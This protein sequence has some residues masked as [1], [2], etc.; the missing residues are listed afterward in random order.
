MSLTE[1]SSSSCMALMGR[2]SSPGRRSKKVTFAFLLVT[3]CFFCL[4]GFAQIDVSPASAHK[5]Y[6][7]GPSFGQPGSGPGQLD[8]PVGV[9][10]ND[11]AE[12]GDEQAGDVYVADTGNKRVEVFSS[13]GVF[14][15]Q[16]NGSGEYEVT[17]AGKLEKKT[18]AAAP[19][20]AFTAPE[21]VAVDNSTEV[22]DPSKGDVYVTDPERKAIDKFTAK[23]E[24][25]EQITNTEGCENEAFPEKVPPCPGGKAPIAIPF[26]ELRNVAVDPSGDLWVFEAV[27]PEPETTGYM[28]EFN[29]T[30]G[31]MRRVRIHYYEKLG[32]HAL[33]VD[34]NGD[35]YVN[36]GDRILKLS[37]EG[38]ELEV[39]SEG[40]N[41]L[42][43]VPSASS[44]LAN[45]LFVDKGGSIVRYG[46]FGEPYSEPL[47]S[48][49]GEDVPK[50]FEG[51]SGSEGLAVNATAV[52][53]A[54]ERGAGADR[55]Q[56]FVYVPVPD[57]VTKAPSEVSESGLTLQGTVNPEGEAV[58]ECFFE[59]GTDVGKYTAKAPC[60]HEK[61]L[62]GTEAV[63]VKAV[64]A[65][66]TPAQVRSFRVVAVSAMGVPGDGE[67]LTI[68]R[69]VVTEEGVSGVGSV[70]ATAGGE[71]D[72]GSLESCYRV[73]YGTSVAYGQSA[74]EV[75]RPEVCVPAGAGPVAVGVDLSGLAPG[76]TYHFRIV[77]RNALGAGPPGEDFV[78]VTFPQTA[79]ALP[80]G[81]VYEL[82][83]PVGVGYGEVYAPAGL[84]EGFDA[85]GL[86]G[87]VTERPSQASV[88]GEAVVYVGDPPAS[89]GNGD[90]GDGLGNEYVAS[91]L[92]GGG[93]SLVDLDPPG[94]ANEYNA[95]SD[96]LSAGVLSTA[97]QLAPGA[98]AG[99]RNLYRRA[100]VGGVFEPFVAAAPGCG[101]GAFG[102]ILNNKLEEGKLL[103]SGG[104]EG[105]GTVAPFNELLFEAD[106]GLP[107]E[108]VMAPEGCGA[109][110]D[111]YEWVG[112]RLY[113]VNVLPDGRVEPD[114]TFGRQGPKVNGFANPE[115][116]NVVSADGSRVYWSAVEAVPVGNEFEERPKALYVRENATQ[117][118]SEVEG[119]ECTEPAKACTVQV[120]AVEAGCSEAV[121]GKGKERGGRGLFW[122]AST[123][124]SKVF[125]TDERPLT[126]RSTPG[127]DLYEY[128]LQAPAGE[129]LTNLSVPAGA[130]EDADV[131]GLVGV[132]EDGEYV[133]FVADG[134]LSEGKSAKGREPASGEP[135]LYLRHAG[136]TTFI[137]TL[138]GKDDDFTAGSEEADGDWQA[139]TGHRT[140]GVTPDGRSLVFMS[141]QRLTGYDSER[142][143]TSVTEV[144]VYDARSDRL[145]CASC[146][147][148][149]EGPATSNG[150]FGSFLPVSESLVGYQPRVISDDGS[151]VFFD[152]IEPLVAQHTSGVLNVYEWEREGTVGC[153]VATSRWGGCIYLLSGGQSAE[154]SYFFDASAS[155]SDVFFVS[156]ADLVAADRG[157]FDELY[158]ARVGG[159]QLPEPPG[160]AGAGCQGIPPAPPIY[161]TPASVTFNG[162]GNYPPKPPPTPPKPET[163]AQKLA[164]ALK[165]CKQKYPHRKSKRQACE[166][167]ART[168]YAVK[169]SSAHKASRGGRS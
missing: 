14:Q 42:A 80:D 67:G 111:L 30:G 15:G 157:E 104:N 130:G 103:F 169:K 5:I 83:S 54:S 84:E 7:P 115:I 122:A 49:P 134:V 94:Y 107:S 159:V 100:T 29:A 137:A 166:R 23:G 88:S 40:A 38:K 35:I 161:A 52:V 151:R 56:S 147:P 129:R 72:P 108:P 153:P 39:F 63:S 136:V 162:T 131:Q 116:S 81:R 97:E 44:Q 168:T 2:V 8:E 37:A 60:E 140:A 6:F 149:G 144:F 102:S 163:R 20:G 114:A 41:T 138:S 110:N 160:C 143:G 165:A 85:E 86:H 21:Q 61:P 13:A 59:Y 73:E 18:G 19:G 17:V 31:F 12:L 139:D 78:F 87:I 146:N 33:T 105:T 145:T 128:D 10:V 79:S 51:L 50:G 70:V 121:C 58:K 148:S 150:V 158:D 43:F 65:G 106:G 45:A 120:D 91:R 98:P 47:E 132:S 119:G 113:L 117:P 76:T 123:D 48:F 11:S 27:K 32:H 3:F 124:G 155:G 74:P 57:A 69:P 9:A 93:W 109:A 95:F 68:A 75:S 118:E 34:A 26:D 46:P 92:P 62:E 90:V 4:A 126:E 64:L 1:C 127:P 53:Y 36:I 125:F 96:D 135:N 55:V 167:A 25:I 66:L 133:Y 82:V 22:G 141:R 154:N 24:Y 77:A 16:F 71:L 156:R 152:S 142:G 89:G 99:Y 112:G 101:P 28:D 164:K